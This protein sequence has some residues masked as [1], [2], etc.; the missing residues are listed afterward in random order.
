MA[1]KAAKA[2]RPARV[3]PVCR[4]CGRG[5]VPKRR[6]QRYCN[7]E[8]REA[9][10][11]V[12]YFAQTTAEKTCPNCGNT[13]TTTKPKKQ[14]YCSPDCREDAR[15]KRIEAAGASM[16]AERVTY[17]GERIAA[18]ERDEFKCTVCGRGPKDGAVLDVVE[19]GSELVTVCT[20]CKIG[21]GGAK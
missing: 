21:K 2:A 20:D 14:V 18:F 19:E 11:K 16:S 12:H 3:L 7:D 9:Y 15:K 17:L 8:C 4:N 13:F 6:S 10:Y 1:K 5:F